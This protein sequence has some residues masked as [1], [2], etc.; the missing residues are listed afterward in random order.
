MELRQ[1]VTFVRIV[2]T[3]SFTR[4][5]E[6]LGYTQAAVTIQIRELEREFGT[7]F[8]ERIGR[9]IALTPPGEQF[10]QYARDIL[11]QAEEARKALGA[12]VRGR[13]SLRIGTLESL[14]SAKLPPVIRRFYLNRPE[15]SLKIVTGSPQELL[16]RMNRNEVDL[17]YL[18][19][20]RLNDQRWVKALEQPEPIVFV[21]SARNHLAK[22]RDIPLD[23]LW[24]Q[25]FFLTESESNYRRALDQLLA[26]E[27]RSVHPVCET[28]STALITRLI[29]ENQGVSF[30][31][32]FAV[33][34][35]IRRG[36]LAELDVAGFR[37]EMYRQVFYH[38]D[39]WVTEEMRDLIRMGRNGML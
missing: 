6:S 29:G 25:P 27:R 4:A 34:E 39:K 38:R 8:F 2:E 15:L 11:H 32:R 5:A 7:K 36:T 14:Q 16:D 22:A 28:G 17:V 20:H 33:E 19:D 26:A 18:L 3:Q 13:S 1:L 23:S 21:C 9:N 12:P 10:A 31:P 24:D 30:L 35:D 37:L